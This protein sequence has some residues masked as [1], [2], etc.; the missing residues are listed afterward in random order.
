MLAENAS[1]GL[2]N[3]AEHRHALLPFLNDRSEGSIEFKHQNIS[4]VLIGLGEIRIPGCK[5]AF[6]QQMAVEDAVVRCADF[7][8]SFLYCLF[9]RSNFFNTR[10]ALSWLMGRGVLVGLDSR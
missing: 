6:R 5:P 4:A 8:V 1:G 7:P 10:P 9:E 2:Y 3:Q